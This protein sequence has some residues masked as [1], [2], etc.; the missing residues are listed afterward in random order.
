[1]SNSPIKNPIGTYVQAPINGK[2]IGMLDRTSDRLAAIAQPL[3][4]AFPF[5]TV[6]HAIPLRKATIG[7]RIARIPRTAIMKM[8]EGS[9]EDRA[10]GVLDNP[11]PAGKG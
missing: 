10:P 9:S 2:N 11:W 5:F 1:M 6:H 8:E 4:E 3:A 7:G